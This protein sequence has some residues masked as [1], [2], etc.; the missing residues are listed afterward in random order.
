MLLINGSG[1][2]S[3]FFFKEAPASFSFFKRLRFPSPV[4]GKLL[5][6]ERSWFVFVFY[7][8]F[9]EIISRKIINSGRDTI[10][11]LH[12]MMGNAGG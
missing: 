12:Y 2:G 3:C 7:S 5:I 8:L 1:S 4:F 9:V 6:P 11:G 10:S